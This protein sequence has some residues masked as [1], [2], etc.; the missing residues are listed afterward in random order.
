[1]RDIANIRKEYQQAELNE[2]LVGD[3]PID[4][5]A[6][7][8]GEAQA[9]DADEVN[10]MTLATVD[11]NNHPHARIVLLK[12]VDNQE[13]V[14]YTNYLSDKGQEMA[15]NP[16]VSLLFFWK[17]LERQVRIEGTVSKTASQISDEYFASRPDGS[18][19]G[20]WSSPQSRIIP[21]RNIL[22]ENYLKYENRFS[23]QQIPRPEHWGGYSVKPQRM[24]FWQGRSNRMH[25]RVVFLLSDSG[26]WEKHRLAP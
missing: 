12:G 11:G 22:D 8:F 20:A 19:L 3:D 15:A 26:V 9:A 2:A 1:M 5:F 23:D 7:W 18:K 4:F 25:D 21:N 13:F 6:K 14:F 16:N 10:A 24:E 17:E